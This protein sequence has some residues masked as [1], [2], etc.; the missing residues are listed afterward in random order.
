MKS[1]NRESNW[2]N[3]IQFLMCYNVSS[4]LYIWIMLYLRRVTQN[5][6]FDFA[7][8]FILLPII[9]L[10]NTKPKRQFYMLTGISG[11]TILAAT[12]FLVDPYWLK[13]CY[14][15]T[16]FMILLLLAAESVFQRKSAVVQLEEANQELQKAL[17]KAQQM[18]LQANEASKAKSQFLANM[19]HE[20]R[21]PLNSIIGFSNI[22]L[23]NKEN[24]LRDKDCDYLQRIS[25][26]GNLLLSLVND[27]LDL[28]KVEAGRMDC[29]FETVD[30]GEL[31]HEIVSHIQS[32]ADGKKLKLYTQIPEQLNPIRTDRAKVKQILVN[33]L[34]N[35]IKFTEQG[36]VTVQVDSDGESKKPQ[37][38]AVID[39]G[40][41]ISSDKIETIFDVFQQGDYSLSRK[42]GGTGLGLAICKSLSR[43]LGYSL[44]VES[45]EKKG[46]TFC[47][48][49]EA[50]D[51]PPFSGNMEMIQNVN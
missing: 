2:S 38:I 47:I 32:Q 27:I 46:S 18:T 12:L 42:Y 14:S 24:N 9:Y 50:S 44:T 41:G 6:I 16:F 4:I 19:S 30:V 8:A 43:L 3:L 31:V 22:L 1:P 40:I 49:L 34:S 39:T 13:S 23:K 25:S 26:N 5:G 36:S 15:L 35:A 17:E 45:E 29:H 48:L 7:M 10:A 20:L 33:L 21:T 28:S 51:S 37:R 11:Y